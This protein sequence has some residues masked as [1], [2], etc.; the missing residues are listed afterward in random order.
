LEYFSASSI[1]FPF[2]LSLYFL[3]SSP[4]YFRFFYSYIYISLLLEIICVTLGIYHVHNN[5]LSHLDTLNEV[6]FLGYF[7]R[8]I[9]QNK[10][11]RKLLYFLIPILSLF[12]IINAFFIQGLD[13]FNSYSR[14]ISSFFFILISLGFFTQLFLQASS[15][16]IEQNSLFWITAGILF[17]FS[18]T[19]FVFLMYRNKNY[20]MTDTLSVQI[21]YLNSIF[22]IFQNLLFSIGIVCT[23][24]M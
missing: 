14:T 21:W 7:Y 13:H 15:I 17:Y 22:N 24:K 11:I 1:L 6:I 2:V 10:I 19:L 8:Q 5:F 9:F 12:I 3:K 18:S 23:R 16:H 20:N 4:K